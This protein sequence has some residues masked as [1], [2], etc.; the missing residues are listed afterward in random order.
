MS[1]AGETWWVYEDDIAA[2]ARVHKASCWHCNNGRGHSRLPSNRWHGPY[3]SEAEAL[4][5]AVRLWPDDARVCNRC[6]GRGTATAA[7]ARTP[8]TWTAYGSAWRRFSAW[9]EE[10]GAQA[11][12]ATSEDVGSYLLERIA[13][14]RTP[15][16][17][18]VDAGAISAQHRDAGLPDPTRAESVLRLVG[19]QRSRRRGAARRGDP[20]TAA[21]LDQVLQAI[22]DTAIGRRDRALLL[23]MRDCRL[24]PFEA[25]ALRW[26][27]VAAGGVAIA[28]RLTQVRGSVTVDL[29]LISER[30]RQALAA[31]LPDAER[32]PEQHVFLVVTAP[33]RGQP[34]SGDTVSD[35]VRRRVKAAGIEGRHPMSVTRKGRPHPGSESGCRVRDAQGD[36]EQ[37]ERRV[38]AVRAAVFRGRRRRREWSWPA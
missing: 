33:R 13:Q 24:R 35:I 8:A 2:H 36:R 25:A 14:G 26:R 12:P 34:L 17:V 9:C 23:V 5:L 29:W 30:A 4:R 31:L 38:R 28:V 22:P 19:E 20:L 18:N 7:E 6:A 32:D 21:R 27:D 10:R 11:L 16:T 3:A 15:S 37:S 1:E